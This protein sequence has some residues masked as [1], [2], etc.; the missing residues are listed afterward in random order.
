MTGS[1][2]SAVSFIRW[3][4]GLDGQK[5]DVWMDRLKKWIGA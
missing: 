5:M 1:F 3:I 2:L 4:N